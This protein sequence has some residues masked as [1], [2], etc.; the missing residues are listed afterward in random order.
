MKFINLAGKFFGLIK[1]VFNRFISLSFWKKVIVV[2]VLVV[3]LGVLSYRLKSA[4]GNG[5][6]VTER[7][8][9]G[10]VTEIVS[11]SGKIISGGSVEISSPTKG[12]I[13]EIFVEN[14]Q[15]VKE[16]DKL[17]TVKSSATAQE[18]QA[19]YSAYLT[20]V[21]ALKA[22]QDLAHSLRSV[23]YTDWKTF[24]DLATNDTY[25]TSEGVAR[26]SN[27]SAAEF[28]STKEDWLAAESKVKD[29][30]AAMAANQ[31]AV[32]NAWTAYQAT[33]TTTVTAQVPG[34]VENLSVSVGNSVGVLSI[35]TP[36]VTPVLTIAAAAAPE[37]MIAVGQ[38]NIAKV[39]TGQKVIIHPDSN[40]DKDFEGTVTRVDNIGKNV[41]GV[42]TYNVYLKLNDP[43][44]LLKPEMTVDGD[45][46]TNE[47]KDV[48][49]V[50]NSAVVLYKGGK[51][52][53]IRKGNSMDYIPVTVGIKG[54]TRTE[55]LEGLKD[56]QNII[57]S[58]TNEKVKRPSLLGL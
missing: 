49:T 38:T 46:V 2:T 17:F 53:R 8:S 14:G 50:P 36:D 47:R 9:R 25:E 40:K 3:I 39:R 21:S 13:E 37:A 4:G 11:D 43:G 26:E 31:A 57:V 15:A 19:A 16:D 51:A 34:T 55:I 12:F 52:V 24:L 48:L 58:L 29:Q 18:Q 42:V 10:T 56:G 35:L 32:T 41:Q 5:G 6:Y 54:E 30:D 33:Q 7:V 45:I 20:A 23:M 1:P 22:S 28:Q 44:E 27:R